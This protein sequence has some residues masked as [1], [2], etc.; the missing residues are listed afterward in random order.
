MLGK[1]ERLP[2]G[3]Q[4]QLLFILL[5]HNLKAAIGLSFDQWQ[6]PLL[7]VVKFGFRRSRFHLGL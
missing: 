4:V 5:F 3:Q 6:D 7:V 1:G 2:E